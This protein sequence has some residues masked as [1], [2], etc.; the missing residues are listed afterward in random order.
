MKLWAKDKTNKKKLKIKVAGRV[1]QV[2]ATGEKSELEI[3]DREVQSIENVFDCLLKIDKSVNAFDDDGIFI[4]L[5]CRKFCPL[6]NKDFCKDVV[7]LMDKEL[8][9]KMTLRTSIDISG[10]VDYTR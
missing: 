5:Q 6:A 9:R 10:F 7:N 4:S 8:T 2:T 1:V 3:L